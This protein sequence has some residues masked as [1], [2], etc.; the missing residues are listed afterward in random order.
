MGH[1]ESTRVA[2][3][4][5][6]WSDRCAAEGLRCLSIFNMKRIRNTVSLGCRVLDSQDVDMFLC[7]GVFAGQL[8][9][10]DVAQAPH[11]PGICIL[12]ALMRARDCFYKVMV[13]CTWMHAID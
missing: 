9:D 4:A 2:Y 7:S 5:H 8:Q 3:E 12:M 1:W 6:A 11:R 13:C 10:A